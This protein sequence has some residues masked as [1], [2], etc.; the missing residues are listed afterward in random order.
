MHSASCVV[1]SLHMLLREGRALCS[2]CTLSMIVMCMLHYATCLMQV[3]LVMRLHRPAVP[4]RAKLQTACKNST[5]SRTVLPCPVCSW[6][7]WWGKRP[8]CVTSGLLV[9]AGVGSQAEPVCPARWLDHA[10]AGCT[11]RSSSPDRRLGEPAMLSMQN[12]ILTAFSRCVTHP[13]GTPARAILGQYSLS[14]I[15][16]SLPW[17]GP[18]DAA[19]T[20]SACR[21]CPCLQHMPAPTLAAFRLHANSC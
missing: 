15:P 16:L 1:G 19:F 5:H 12:R 4:G 3:V 14:S 10:D 13:G 9:A 20:S 18:T 21:P 11:G 7:L 2:E 17:N 6:Q 8:R